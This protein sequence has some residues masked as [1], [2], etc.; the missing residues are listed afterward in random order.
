MFILKIFFCIFLISKQMNLENIRKTFFL[1]N[2]FFQGS[3]CFLKI[4]IEEKD[5]KKIVFLCLYKFIF[6]E[7]QYE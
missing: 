1:E 4:I 5:V 2:I 3:R 6:F 7:S